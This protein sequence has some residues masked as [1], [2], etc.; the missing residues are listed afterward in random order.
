MRSSYAS[1][2]ATVGQ[3]SA[4]LL[5]SIP[6]A[7]L[8]WFA[9]GKSETREV[10]AILAVLLAV[11]WVVPATVLLGAAS[12]PIYMWLH[13]QGPVPPVLDWLGGVVL[14]AAVAGAHI[15]AALAA[16]CWRARRTVAE[17]GLR[18]FLERTTAGRPTDPIDKA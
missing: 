7:G 17:P 10:L 15:N 2:P 3:W 4:G 12:A 13:T 9:D 16:A 8:L 1:W 11:P 6:L 18:E 5:A 14:M